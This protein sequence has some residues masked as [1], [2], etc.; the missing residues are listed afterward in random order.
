MPDPISIN[1]DDQNQQPAT[2]QTQEQNTTN[3][4]SAGNTQSASDSEL[5]K[6]QTEI[7]QLKDTLARTQ[8]DFINFRRR[9]TQENESMIKFAASETIHTLLPVIDNLQRSFSHIPTELKDHVWV[10]GV[11][12]IEKQ[13]LQTL[14]KIG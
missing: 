1:F 2:D 12:A 13:F 5:T 9:Q 4:S 8:A 10:N 14:E 7:D 3:N 6:L 11:I